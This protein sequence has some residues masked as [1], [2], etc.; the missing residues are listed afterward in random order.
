[1]S[2]AP[3]LGSV[4]P[5]ATCRFCGQTTHT[6]KDVEACLQKLRPPGE[7]PPERTSATGCDEATAH[8]AGP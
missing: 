7:P 8:P 1:M 6:A 2:T 5:T 3:V 4:C